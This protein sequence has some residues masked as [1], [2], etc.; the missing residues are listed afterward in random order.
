M[1]LSPEKTE[2]YYSQGF[3]KIVMQPVSR[4]SGIFPFSIAEVLIFLAI[5]YILTRLVYLTVK[6]IR[7]RS[8]STFLPFLSNVVLAVSLCF[9][10]QTVIWSINYERLSFADNADIQ[11]QDSSVDE[12][13]AM[14]RLLIR[15]TNALREK[16]KEDENGV[17]KI[18]GGFKTIADR[19]NLGYTAIQANYP[20]LGGQ[21]GPPKP[22]FL[23]KPMSGT[24]II[25][26]YACFTGEANVDIDIPAMEIPS[27]AMHEMAHQRGFARED[28]ANYI[29]YA[30]CMAHPDI[31]FK[32]SGSVLALQYSMNALYSADSGR[33]FELF[34]SYSP[35][36]LRDLKY[37]QAYW[38]KF[39]GMTRKVA[40]KINDSYL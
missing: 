31:E 35:A 23:S 40:D 30:T 22:V 38:N 29:A 20:F 26:V 13:E 9:F 27:T 10:I 18:D 25:G 33:Y 2:K 6:A 37:E 17:M 32:Y 7:L 21:Y 16:V 4:L 11:V 3:Y 14:C 24:N 5:L 36:Y 28:E 19:A 12:L 8:W 39:R 34:R 15:N 1:S